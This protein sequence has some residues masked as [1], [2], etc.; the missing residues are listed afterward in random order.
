MQIKIEKSPDLSDFFSV[1]CVLNIFEIDKNIKNTFVCFSALRF[2]YFDAKNSSKTRF[3]DSFYP[4][5]PQLFELK[6]TKEIN[7]KNILFYWSKTSQNSPKNPKR[8]CISQ[9]LSKIKKNYFF[10]VDGRWS[11]VVSPKLPK[12]IKKLFI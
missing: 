6:H 4:Q 1:V 2:T 12:I 7:T 9:K 3:S 11:L 5:T 10:L 8:K